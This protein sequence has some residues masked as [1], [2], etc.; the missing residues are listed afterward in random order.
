M[1]CDGM[2]RRDFI[3]LIGGVA[4]WPLAPRAQQPMP[5][6]G[7]LDLRSSDAPADLLQAFF[8]RI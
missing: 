6:V 5:V 8:V 4:V 2:K 3:T 7:L 1:Q